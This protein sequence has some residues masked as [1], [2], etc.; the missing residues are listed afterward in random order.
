MHSPDSEGVM[1]EHPLEDYSKWDAWEITELA[2]LRLDRDNSN[3]LLDECRHERNVLQGICSQRADAIERLQKA[4]TLTPDD[5]QRLAEIEA[6]YRPDAV[7]GTHN[8][9]VAW[10]IEKVREMAR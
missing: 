3:L 6:A 9:S 1:S 4:R 5:E 2:F 8:E 7:Y 10:L